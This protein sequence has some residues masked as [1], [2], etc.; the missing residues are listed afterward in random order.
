MQ[1]RSYLL[2]KNL[3]PLEFGRRIGLAHPN[4]VYRYLAGRM[5]ADR[6]LVVINRETEGAVTANDFH[7]ARVSRTLARRQAQA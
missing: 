4:G 3:T 7:V 5:P 2:A 6:F 1:L